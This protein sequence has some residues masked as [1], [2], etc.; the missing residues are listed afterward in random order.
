MDSNLTYTKSLE[1]NKP[2]RM[3][4]V[5]LLAIVSNIDLI[6]HMIPSNARATRLT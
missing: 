4:I 3:A 2:L 1:A 6:Q 5:H